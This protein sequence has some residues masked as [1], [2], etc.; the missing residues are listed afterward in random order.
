[1][2]ICHCSSF[3]KSST[4]SATALL[5]EKVQWQLPMYNPQMTTQTK[6]ALYK[7]LTISHLWSRMGTCTWQLTMGAALPL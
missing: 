7:L 6:H 1:M 3:G 4:G 5:V 2:G